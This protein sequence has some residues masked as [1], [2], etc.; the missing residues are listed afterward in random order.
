MSRFGCPMNIITN[1]DETFKSKRLVSSCNQYNITLGH[2]TTYY[3]QGNGLAESLNKGLVRIIKKVL[4]ENK[5][6][7][8]LK[9]KFSLWADRIC[10]KRYIGVSL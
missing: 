8:H 5:L 7:W 1:N 6:S 10:T 4:Q 2:S 9:L 3:L